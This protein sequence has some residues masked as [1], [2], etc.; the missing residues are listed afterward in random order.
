MIR[1][2][3]H[4]QTE[5]RHLHIVVQ[6]VTTAL[7][8]QHGGLRSEKLQVSVMTAGAPPE[9]ADIERF[10]LD[11]RQRFSARIAPGG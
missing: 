10:C 11:A 3:A 2:D 7:I 4:G 5:R 1:R 6:P 9:P 8:A